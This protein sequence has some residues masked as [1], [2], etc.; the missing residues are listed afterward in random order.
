[1]LTSQSHDGMYLAE[2]SI[3]IGLPMY[4]AIGSILVKQLWDTECSIL[5]K[6]SNV[7]SIV[8]EVWTKLLSLRTIQQWSFGPQ[9]CYY[10]KITLTWA[11]YE[12]GF[13][14]DSYFTSA[15]SAEEMIQLSL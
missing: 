13:C 2:G 11:D 8:D 3:N 14:A 15:S 10:Q 9:N 12:Q 7:N 6:R 1:M 5:I 4:I